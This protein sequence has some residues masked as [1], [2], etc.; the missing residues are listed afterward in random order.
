MTE[1]AGPYSNASVRQSARSEKCL[2]SVKYTNSISRA[3][4]EDKVLSSAATGTL[5]GIPEDFGPANLMHGISIF[6]KRQN[7][8]GSQSDP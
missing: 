8:H 2:F 7:S 5:V 4:D 6:L 3:S 1:I